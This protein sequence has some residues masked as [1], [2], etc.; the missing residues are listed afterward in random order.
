MNLSSPAFA[1][2]ELISSKYTWDGE[3][4]SPLAMERRSRAGEISGANRGR[5]GWPSR[6]FVHWLLLQ[7]PVTESGLQARMDS[8]RLPT[9]AR[10]RQ[11]ARTPTISVCI[12]WTRS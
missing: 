8:G 9:V 12:R 6:V 4:V 10:V 11:T 5:S 2:G 1:E 3:N 7:M